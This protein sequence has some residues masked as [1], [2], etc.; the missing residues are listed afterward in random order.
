MVRRG[1][2]V[3][4]L[5]SALRTPIAC[6]VLAGVQR[7][8]PGTLPLDEGALLVAISPA[9]PPCKEADCIADDPRRRTR[10]S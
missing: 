8:H 6:T 4:R 1:R 3:Q 9:N 10:R 7:G 5:A 2:A